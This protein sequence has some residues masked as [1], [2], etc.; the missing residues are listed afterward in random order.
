MVQRAIA[1]IEA[2]SVVDHGL[3]LGAPKNAMGRILRIL[4]EVRR[5]RQVELRSRSTQHD[6]G[7]GAVKVLVAPVN[8]ECHATLLAASWG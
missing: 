4:G 3:V 2:A 5:N 1:D 7:A 8:E 6:Q